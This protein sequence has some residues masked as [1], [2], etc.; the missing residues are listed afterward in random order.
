MESHEGIECTEGI[1]L[2]GLLSSE[3]AIE[4]TLTYIA[5]ERVIVRLGGVPE[6]ILSG[7]CFR[8]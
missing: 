8:H 3:T 4:L 1:P 5:V 2:M 7:I 6:W